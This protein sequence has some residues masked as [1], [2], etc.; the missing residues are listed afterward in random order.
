MYGKIT[1]I[2][3][4]RTAMKRF[5]GDKRFYR[6][7][8]TVALPIIIQNAIT[9]FVS[10]LDN[11]MVGSVGTEA[12]TGVSIVNQLFFVFNLTVFGAI[13][14]AGIFTAQYHGLADHKGEMHTFR[15]K[16]IVVVLGSIIGIVLF[17][18]GGEAL[19]NTFIHDSAGEAD[20]ILTMNYAEEYLNIMLWGLIP[21]AIAQAYAS[22]LRETGKTMPPMVASVIAVA[23]NVCLNYVLIYG[24]LGA[25]AMGAKGAAT[26][27]VIARFA[28]VIILIV[29]T[30]ANNKK[31]SFIE[32]AY[33]SAYIPGNLVWQITVKG[34]PLMLNEML[35]SMGVTITNQC[36]STRGLD[37]L[38]AVNIASTINN[39]F[40]I[41]FLSMG[42]VIAIIVGNQLGAGELEKAKDTDRK[43]IALSFASSVVMAALLVAFARVFPMFYNTTDAVREL[44]AYIITIFALVMP[45]HALA[46][47]SYF[48]MRSGGQVMVT[49]LFDSVFMWV[50][51]IPVARI[52]ADFTT[53][54]IHFLFPICHG[55]EIIK[56]VLGL[57]L[58]SRGGWV[59]QLVSNTKDK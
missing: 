21:Y 44:A 48:T 54:S 37:A 4:E 14:A 40:S 29:W 25:P 53:M 1:E 2:C 36:Y 34:M 59:K 42:S 26:A 39:L 24:K 32:G 18:F 3:V 33:R 8:M 51:A 43:L 22:T 52:L 56:A 6:M 50:I 46:H 7:V 23:T 5:I 55:L 12:M 45:S 28:E 19:I 10:L 41:V 20:P 58:V 31:C 13:S 16:F 30:H 11:V 9:N 47:G 57:I 15:F 27:T 49:I 17:I 35:W 38:A